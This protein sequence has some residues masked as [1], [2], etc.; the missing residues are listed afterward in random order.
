MS[1]KVIYYLILLLVSIILL[2]GCMQKEITKKE[3][4]KDRK[5]A[6]SVFKIKNLLEMHSNSP[7]CDIHK[8]IS[9]IYWKTY[10]CIICQK[11]I[12]TNEHKQHDYENF[13]ETFGRVKGITIKFNKTA[14][15]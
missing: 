2:S 5:Y 13:N 11:C 8:V 14:C 4:V 15:S 1:K 7:H 12:I 10:S 3:L 6:N 9:D